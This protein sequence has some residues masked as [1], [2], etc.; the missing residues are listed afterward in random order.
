VGAP[1]GTV[2]FLFTDV[3]GSTARWEADPEGMRVALAAHDGVLAEAIESRGG[4]MFKHTGDGVCAAF[5]SPR[6][7]VDAARD[8]QSRLGLPVRMG[9]ATG[10][11]ELRDGDY[12]GPA[13]NRAARVMGAGH[14]GQVLVAAA[15]AAL[16]GDAGLIPLGDHFLAGL[17]SAETVFQADRGVHPP[18]RTSQVR[19]SNLPAE[20]SAFVGREHEV[21]EVVAALGAA[22]AVTL[23]GIGGVGKTR[24]GL[25]A[26][27][28]LTTSFADGVWL[29][30]LAPLSDPASLVDVVAAALGIP[31]RQ[32]QPLAVTVTDHLL[33]R[34]VLV[35]L[36]N[37]E[38]LGD[39]VA[40]WATTILGA[41]PDV[42]LLA[43]SRRRLGVP[44]EHVV[45]VSP[46]RL[47]AVTATL[48]DVS[49][50]EAVQLFI[51]RAVAAKSTFALTE[52]NAPAVGRLVRM[53]DGIPLAIE[54][55][56]ARVRSQSPAELADLF[57]RTG[58]PGGYEPLRRAIEWSH[59]L[60]SDAERTAL[61][62]ASVFAGTFDRAAAEAVIN[63]GPGIV[64]LL[65]AL[66]D[67]SLLIAEDVD[68]TTR[69][70]L[71]E[72]IR[73]FAAEHLDASGKAA[74]C[75]DRHALYYVEFAERAHAG[76]L[77]KE[78]ALWTARVLDELDNLRAVLGWVTARGEAALGL[79]LVGALQTGLTTPAVVTVAWAMP[80]AQLD[81]ARAYPLYAVVLAYAGLAHAYE[82][83]FDA[84]ERCVA[85][86]FVLADAAGA[87]GSA[88]CRMLFAATWAA[89]VA[90]D[91][92]RAG[93]LSE[94]WLEAA[95]SSG[96][97]HQL[98]L[99][100]GHRGVNLMVT[101]RDPPLGRA[102]AREL[103]DLAERDGSPS[104]MVLACLANGLGTLDEAPG[105]ALALFDRGLQS[106]LAVNNYNGAGVCLSCQA[107]VRYEQGDMQLAASLFSRALDLFRQGTSP[108][109]G[110]WLGLAA[111]LL[112]AA[113]DDEGSATLRG[114]PPVIAGR[115]VFFKAK[116]RLATTEPALRARIGDAA[117]ERN[118]TNGRALG[119]DAAIRFVSDHLANRYVL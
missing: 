52:A 58:T 81:G 73:Q 108:A 2:T 99:A 43:T 34:E 61:R 13:L 26:A 47:P 31:E 76:I 77:T 63:V 1:T 107:W 57:E 59:G 51:E 101:R 105:A 53:L 68:G 10:E 109:S 6:A 100:L 14:G 9:I 45:A 4:W 11:A 112:E 56:A 87:S 95:R 16:V 106:A 104:A 114:A 32:G 27:A 65:D 41:C 64:D 98:M 35:V 79:R 71:L 54:L 80:V 18:L 50:A 92:E 46:L 102:I 19:R 21:A 20:L 117:F 69:Y 82:G 7:A 40:L 103:L 70:R 42:R 23:V 111:L 91:Y 110:A 62:D 24:L 78:E 94:Q 86:A 72:T 38:H 113:G 3:E 28:E 37:C 75:R 96:D 88:H 89:S 44:G 67:L 8:A 83:D 30:P 17:R 90:G 48:A 115:A 84:A 116:E 97:L 60:L 55:A 118:Q 49:G 93:E 25:R 33:G 39:A 119:T 74:P 66:V 85:E 22:R 36:D 29:A 5:S 12:F 15:T